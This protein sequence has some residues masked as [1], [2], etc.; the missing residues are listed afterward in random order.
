MVERTG[1][2]M[3]GETKMRGRAEGCRAEGGRREG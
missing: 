2:D 3:E 1:R